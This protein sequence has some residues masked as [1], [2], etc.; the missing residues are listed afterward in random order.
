M[1]ENQPDAN[2]TAPEP[3]DVLIPINSAR[4]SAFLGPKPVLVNFIDG[5]KFLPSSQLFVNTGP[6]V[7]LQLEGSP[8]APKLKFTMTVVNETET[9]LTNTLHQAILEFGFFFKD[10]VINFTYKT[11]FTEKKQAPKWTKPK[12][13]EGKQRRKEV[14]SEKYTHPCAIILTFRT[15]GGVGYQLRSE[16]GVFE[17]LGDKITSV[18]D[19]LTFMSS[20]TNCDTF[21]AFSC[22]LIISPEQADQFDSGE[23]FKTTFDEMKNCSTSLPW[24]AYRGRQQTI[25]TQFGVMRPRLKVWES[26]GSNGIIQVPSE[27][28]FHDLDEVRVKLCY[29]AKLEFDFQLI[30]LKRLMDVKHEVTFVNFGETMEQVIAVI[31]FSS[32]LNEKITPQNIMSLHALVREGTFCTL[33]FK[34]GQSEEAK[35]CSGR[36]FLNVFALPFQSDLIISLPG[37]KPKGLKNCLHQY[38]PPEKPN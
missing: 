6:N 29:G 15:R 20:F 19:L 18:L 1:T 27:N 17:V 24:A 10:E 21:K 25:I 11:Q 4:N 36:T 14:E 28:Y 31:K 37:R 30:H 32:N 16:P 34:D 33:E 35:K 22:K 7:K 9:S 12:K 13:G 23:L 38:P 26:W 8:M 3:D 5:D 2:P